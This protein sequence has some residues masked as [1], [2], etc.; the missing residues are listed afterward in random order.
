MFP[1]RLVQ[2][3]GPENPLGLI[4]FDVRDPFNVAI[5]D[6]P[7]RALFNDRVRIFSHGCVRLDRAAVLATHLLPEWSL[8]DVQSAL[9]RLDSAEQF[10]KVVL[11][12]R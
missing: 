4:R 8:D 6:T 11:S 3:S 9:E 1:Y 2:R 5:H 10:G 12:M 7:Q